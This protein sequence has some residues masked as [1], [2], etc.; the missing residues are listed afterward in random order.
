MFYRVTDK[1]RVLFILTVPAVIVNFILF[2]FP[3]PRS[4]DADTPSLPTRENCDVINSISSNRQLLMSVFVDSKAYIL[5]KI[6]ASC[7]AGRC[8]T[9][10]LNIAPLSAPTALNMA[11]WDAGVEAFYLPYPLVPVFQSK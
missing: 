6:P 7:C 2:F 8:V 3:L 9:T 11:I 5:P 10:L 4:A 1:N